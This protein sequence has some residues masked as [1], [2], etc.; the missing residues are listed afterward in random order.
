MSRPV[1][2]QAGL[3]ET[4]TAPRL[5]P[6]AGAIREAATARTACIFLGSSGSTAHRTGKPL[7]V[8]CNRQPRP[9]MLGSQGVCNDAHIIRRPWNKNGGRFGVPLRGGLSCK[10]RAAKG[11]SRPFGLPSLTRITRRH[12]AKRE[13]EGFALEV[14]SKGASAQLPTPSLRY[15]SVQPVP[16][17]A[18]CSLLTQSRRRAR[19][20]FRNPKPKGRQ[21]NEGQPHRRL[22]PHHQ[23]DYC[24]S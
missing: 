11:A 15:G 9:S 4:Q 3:A 19:V 21:K 5:T 14:P 8:S 10:H 1:L 2:P 16:R 22:Q 20:A 13:P 18:P 23:P 17:E 6:I 7:N 24:R 12:A